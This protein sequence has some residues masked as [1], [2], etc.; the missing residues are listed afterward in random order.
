VLG[1]GGSGNRSSLPVPGGDANALNGSVGNLA[2][3]LRAPT[4]GDMPGAEG[5]VAVVA[6]LKNGMCR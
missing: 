3:F 4:E 1:L 2:F 6:I 5:V